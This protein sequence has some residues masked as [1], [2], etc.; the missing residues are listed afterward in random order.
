MSFVYRSPYYRELTFEFSPTQVLSVV[1][2]QRLIVVD[3]ACECISKITST[4][5]AL[6]SKKKGFFRALTGLGKSIVRT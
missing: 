4:V 3:S 5:A 2:P 1:L 6:K